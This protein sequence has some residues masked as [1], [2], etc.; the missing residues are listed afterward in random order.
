MTISM[1]VAA[2]E[3][4]VIGKNNDL[5][6]HLPDD[7]K[8]F[9]NTTKGHVILMGRKCF[10]S[11]GRPLPHRTNIIITRNIQYTQQGAVVVHSLDD[12]LQVARDKGETEVFICG[13]EEIYRQ[14]MDLADTLY[15]TRVHAAIEGDTYFPELD[16]LQWK[17]ETED[18]H[19]ADDKHE[20]SFTFRTYT[21][22]R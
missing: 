5:P 7:L 6:W 16:P 18:Y 19:P 14:S 17:L 11:F 20:H 12:A 22:I 1:I 8:F 4:G 13:G 3:N 21:K 2:A 10:E 9:K 15:L